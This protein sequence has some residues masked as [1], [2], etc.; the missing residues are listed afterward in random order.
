MQSEQYRSDAVTQKSG[1]FAVPMGS[2]TATIAQS[3]KVWQ[4]LFGGSLLKVSA[5]ASN[6]HCCLDICTFE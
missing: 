4:G 3:Y 6:S 5:A 1:W 2:G